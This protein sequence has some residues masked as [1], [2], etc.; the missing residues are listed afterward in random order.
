MQSFNLLKLSNVKD[1]FLRFIS[2]SVAV[3]AHENESIFM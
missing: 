1:F 2:H 3:M